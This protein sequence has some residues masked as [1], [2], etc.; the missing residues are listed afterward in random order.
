MVCESKTRIHFSR[1]NSRPSQGFIRP[2]ILAREPS[3]RDRGEGA[4]LDLLICI[5]GFF[6]ALEIKNPETG[7]LGP[8]QS[9]EIE[10]IRRASGVA[11]IISSWQDLKKIIDR[12][13]PSQRVIWANE[14]ETSLSQQYQ[15]A[16]LKFRQHMFFVN[17][18]S[19]VRATL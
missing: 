1:P 3:G 5:D 12:F 14:M 11:E 19:L 6:I 17:P 9:K 18:A 16:A 13:E 4:I 10:K 8:K 7:G 2:K 15:I